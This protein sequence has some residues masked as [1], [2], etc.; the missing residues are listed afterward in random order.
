MSRLK[1]V[2]LLRLLEQAP[3]PYSSTTLRRTDPDYVGIL[4]LDGYEQVKVAL[5][6][7]CSRP[8]TVFTDSGIEGVGEERY[9]YAVDFEIGNAA[10]DQF[11]LEDEDD[12]IDIEEE[13]D[14]DDEDA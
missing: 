10:I 12:E 7:M 13:D 5:S 4:Q 6:A 2:W 9:A 3:Y 8:R 11:V 14:D 1:R